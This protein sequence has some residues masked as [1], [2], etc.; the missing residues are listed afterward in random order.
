MVYRLMLAALIKSAIRVAEKEDG[1]GKEDW[2]EEE[3]AAASDGAIERA[4][5]P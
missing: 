2:G 3:D 4:N 1:N 5:N